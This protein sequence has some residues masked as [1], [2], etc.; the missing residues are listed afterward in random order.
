M[1]NLN[2]VHVR[3]TPWHTRPARAFPAAA[4]DSE[5]LTVTDSEAIE[6]IQVGSHGDWDDTDSAVDFTTL[7]QVA[8]RGP[9]TVTVGRDGDD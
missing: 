9:Y 5:G 1:F 8:S 3:F 6:V 4:E 2:L 7:I